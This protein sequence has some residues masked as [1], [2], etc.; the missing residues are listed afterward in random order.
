[1]YAARPQYRPVRLG[2]SQQM[3]GCFS[4]NISPPFKSEVK[5]ITDSI[6]DRCNEN[7]R[8]RAMRGDRGETQGQ[9]YEYKMHHRQMKEIKRERRPRKVVRNDR[10]RSFCHEISPVKNPIEE[11]GERKT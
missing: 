1:M 8:Q 9:E 4:D 10:I 3:A 2:D 7:L 5:T 11:H 6:Y